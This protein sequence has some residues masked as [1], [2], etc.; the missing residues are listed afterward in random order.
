MAF[1]EEFR[2]WTLNSCYFEAS[3]PMMGLVVPFPSG[4]IPAVRLLLLASM[5]DL[6][7]LHIRLKWVRRS[8]GR[9][10]PQTTQALSPA[11]PNRKVKSRETRG[12]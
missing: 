2:R 7:E 8:G 4:P 9:D 1:V 6:L 3:N 10:R 11:Q 5:S 12:S